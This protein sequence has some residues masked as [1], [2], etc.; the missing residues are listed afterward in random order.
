MTKS[1]LLRRPLSE[2]DLT[3]V[4]LLLNPETIMHQDARAGSEFLLSLDDTDLSN[5]FVD[6]AYER[7]PPG[8][9][10]RAFL[11]SHKHA[12]VSEAALQSALRRLSMVGLPLANSLSE[13]NEE[14]P[15]RPVVSMLFSPGATLQEHL[16]KAGEADRAMDG[17][18][19]MASMVSLLE[20][21]LAHLY[22]HVTRT[23]NPFMAITPVIQVT[24]LLMN[25]IDRLHRMQIDAGVIN[26]QPDRLEVDMQVAGAFQTYIGE[27]DNGA[28]EQ[29]VSFAERFG[30]FVKEKKK[31]DKRTGAGRAGTS[32][33]RAG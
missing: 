17:V 9:L 32:G 6:A 19:K 29:M 12:F 22:S 30:Q 26:R 1:T 7:V 27:L 15:E 5:L 4:R 10:A 13:S 14:E 24:S 31:N 2:D 8:D 16:A 11:A 18:A 21:Q 25:A 20:Q 3:R 28:R 23:A 33:N